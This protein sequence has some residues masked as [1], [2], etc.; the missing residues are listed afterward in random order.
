MG[1]TRALITVVGDHTYING[2]EEA[3][4]FFERLADSLTPQSPQAPADEVTQRVKVVEAGMRTMESLSGSPVTPLSVAVRALRQLNSAV[5]VAKHVPDAGPRSRVEH[6]HQ[7]PPQP[8][9][10]HTLPYQ[11]TE[12]SISTASCVQA[13]TADAND[14]GTAPRSSEDTIVTTPELSL[15]L[16]SPCSS[17][18]SCYALSPTSSIADLEFMP[19][20]LPAAARAQTEEIADLEADIKGDSEKPGQSLDELPPD[21]PGKLDEVAEDEPVRS[22]AALPSCAEDKGAAELQVT[23]KG[24]HG[25]FKY[26][27][28]YKH[29]GSTYWCDACFERVRQQL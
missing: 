14:A 12:V 23:C 18:A 4:L 8:L 1:G 17:E 25:I 29:G 10:W 2:K 13:A 5:G 7:P 19:N 21:L 28:G 15:V 26:D 24:R 6:F 11:H 3:R 20:V 22:S 9:D 27:C 16:P